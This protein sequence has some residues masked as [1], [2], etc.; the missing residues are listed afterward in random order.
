MA[1]EK[2]APKVA[3]PK[4]VKEL[5]NYEAVGRRKTAVA[6]VRLHIAASATLKKGD[7]TVNDKPF[8]QYFGALG[9][10]NVLLQPL[11]LAG[12]VDRFGISIKVAGGGSQGQLEAVVL[13]IARAL[14]KVDKG[15]RAIL[16][17]HGLLTRDARE[18]ERRKVGT[19][20]RARRQKQ[21]PKR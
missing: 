16:K 9:Q 4:K 19:G 6:R 14:E 20:G 15:H 11:T 18:R 5:K 10:Q 21:S 8:T 7:I 17:E 13:G 2:K 3:A 12:S 1:T